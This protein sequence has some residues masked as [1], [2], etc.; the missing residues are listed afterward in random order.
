[1]IKKINKKGIALP[2]N[3]LFAIVA[4][5]TILFLAIFAAG[6]FI[7]T[8]EQTIYTETAASL[9]SLFD[10]LETGLASGKAY[11]IGFKKKSKIFF[12]CNENLNPPFGKQTIF[13]SE[14]TFGETYGEVGKEVSIKDKYI[15]SKEV[16]EGEKVYVFSKPLF[17]PF[18]IN[19]IVIL[20][21]SDDK[22]C[23][24]DSPEEIKES[25]EGL[26][27]KNIVFVNETLVCNG[28]NVCFKEK[29]KCDI[30][31]NE[32]QGQVLNKLYKKRVYYAG[33]LIYG[34]I[35]SSPE[36]YECNVKRIKNK[37][38][39][40]ANVYLDKIK[41]IEREGCQSN[42]G[43]KLSKVLGPIN[44]SRELIGLYNEVQEIDSI[45][46]LEKSGCQLYYNAEFE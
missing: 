1:M 46:R 2:F 19:D 37:F 31:V 36:I 32:N 21:S 25:L 12:G 34:A 28:I 20:T 5:G 29:R 44:D 27:L 4:G 30:V 8:S 11:E 38:D 7:R 42:I 41:V 23:F 33:N 35:F 10:P 6:K 17:M 22:Y 18:K 26:N 24:Y 40:L 39:E 16:V 45:N 14:Q 3:W 9:I 15:F 13:F 43:Q